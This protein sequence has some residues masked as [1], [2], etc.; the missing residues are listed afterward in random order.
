METRVCTRDGCG[1]VFHTNDTRRTHCLTPECEKARRRDSYYVAKTHSVSAFA[2][3][4]IDQR[5]TMAVPALRHSLAGVATIPEHQ[6]VSR[7]MAAHP[8]V[9]ASSGRG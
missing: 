5:F 2:Q 4:E 3:A 6:R 8:N 7:H 9:F 1:N